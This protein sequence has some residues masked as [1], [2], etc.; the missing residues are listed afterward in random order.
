[1]DAPD[2]LQRRI[3]AGEALVG[4]IGLGYVGLPLAHTLHEGGGLRILGFDTDPRKIEALAKGRSYIKHLGDAVVQSLSDS[5][6]FAATGDLT[7][8]GECDA[9]IVCVPTDRKSVV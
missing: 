4:I 7:R 6:R 9:I 5:P 8:L 3:Q 2:A 1:M